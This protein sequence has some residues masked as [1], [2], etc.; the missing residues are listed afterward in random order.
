MPHP[1]PSPATALILGGGSD[2]AL[3]IVRRLARKGLRT[4]V[5]AARDPAALRSRLE[6]DAL[7]VDATIEPWDA[8]DPSAHEPLVARATEVLE[9]IDLVVC[10]VGS[11]GHHA[12]LS[13]PSPDADASISTNFAGP[14]AALLAAGRVLRLQRS[15][16]IVVLSSVAG[17]RARKSNFVYGAGKAGLDA[18]AQGLGDALASDGVH[19]MVVRP[20]FVVSKMTTGLDPAP[21]ATTPSAVADAVAAGLARRR[22]VVW[23]PARLGPLF[24]VL[25]NVPAPV[26]RRIAGER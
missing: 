22:R 17:A 11:L 18:F 13:M 1:A 9:T 16:T 5:L 20:G 10:A 25:R 26:W 21:M 6:R 8:L 15:G 23:V 7:P 2:I 12:G 19:V 14:A 4:V 24:G 3:A